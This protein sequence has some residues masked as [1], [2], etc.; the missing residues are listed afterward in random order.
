MKL[1]Y[2]KD[3]EEFAKSISKKVKA[4]MAVQ[5]NEANSA[6]SNHNTSVSAHDDI[7]NLVTELTTRLNALADCD[8]TT[9]DQLSEIVAYIKS[10]R[11]LI[12]NVTTNKVNVSDIIDNLTST[13]ANKALSANQGRILKELIDTLTANIPGEFDF[14]EITDADIDK[15]I[16]GTYTE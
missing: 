11:T 1:I 3:L 2:L 8:D 12:E 10:N 13:A 6:V 4:L 16:N 7:R 14:N 5:Q 15:I 9:L